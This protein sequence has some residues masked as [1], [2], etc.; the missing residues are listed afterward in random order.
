MTIK[1]L[2][3]E[4]LNMPMDARIDFTVYY[5]EEDVFYF[6]TNQSEIQV[7]RFGYDCGNDDSIHIYITGCSEGSD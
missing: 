2:I 4:L 5:E 3:T 1:E 6:S 7:S